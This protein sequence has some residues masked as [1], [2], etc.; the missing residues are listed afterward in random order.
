MGSARLT[1]SRWLDARLHVPSPY[2]PGGTIRTRQGPALRLALVSAG[3]PAGLGLLELFGT[4]PEGFQHAGGH[5]P[6][7]IGIHVDAI[8]GE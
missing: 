6:V 4:Q 7:A 2:L 8:A 5:H 1:R 3:L